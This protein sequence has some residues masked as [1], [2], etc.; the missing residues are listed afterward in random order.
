MSFKEANSSATSTYDSR[1]TIRA[2]RK[3]KSRWPPP[4]PL[5]LPPPLRRRSSRMSGRRPCK[6]TLRSV[7]LHTFY[8]CVFFFFGRCNCACYTLNN[9]PPSFYIFVYFCLDSIELMR[10]S[11][12]VLNF[13]FFT[14]RQFVLNHHFFARLHTVK[15]MLF[16]A[17]SKMQIFFFSHCCC[18]I[19]VDRLHLHEMLKH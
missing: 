8:N 9:T 10:A 19:N 4:P 2:K 17:S 15:S 14:R 1:K 16:C 7:F 18:F 12:F 11:T 3:R 5:Q 6:L 13:F